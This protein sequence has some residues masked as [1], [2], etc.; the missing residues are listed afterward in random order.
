MKKKNWDIH[1]I[2]ATQFILA[3]N[4]RMRHWFPWVWQTRS[5][6]FS[7]LFFF[8]YH[9]AQ[10]LI[11][12]IVKAVF[13]SEWKCSEPSRKATFLLHRA[14]TGGLFSDSR[15]SRLK[16]WN[17]GKCQVFLKYVRGY[18]SLLFISHFSPSVLFYHCFPSP[19]CLS[20]MSVP[21]G[22]VAQCNLSPFI[23]GY[24]PFFVSSSLFTLLSSP[25]VCDLP[26]PF[27]VS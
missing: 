10:W 26:S 8:F 5:V 17:P 23:C 25:C 6:S 18:I 2:K 22:W 20:L 1:R 21:S 16:T 19:W 9:S 14:K 24:T 4:V 13:S 12:L 27:P 15:L 11:F 3:A 7:F